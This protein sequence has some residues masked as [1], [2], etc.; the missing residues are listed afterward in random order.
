MAGSLPQARCCRSRLEL[1]APGLLGLQ[2]V[3]RRCL[4]TDKITSHPHKHTYTRSRFVMQ[5]TS[6]FPSHGKT[7][8][9]ERDTETQDFKRQES[10]HEGRQMQ[11][12]KC[13]CE[14]R[15]KEGGVCAARTGPA[16]A[17][18]RR[19]GGAGCR[20]L[21][22][23]RSWKKLLPSVCVTQADNTGGRGAGRGER[24][25]PRTKSCRDVNHTPSSCPRSPK[26]H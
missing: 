5:F 26:P 13:C 14:G 9:D 4:A 2:R 21:P 3:I 11:E 16:G 25:L 7:R 10:I 17:R 22:A 23:P 20:P 15:R 1:S 19:P 24:Q 12:K 18:E 8:T 6:T